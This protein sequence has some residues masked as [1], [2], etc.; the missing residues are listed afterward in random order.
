MSIQ[1]KT[2]TIS[3]TEIFELYIIFIY[4]IVHK[5][6]I[7]VH[8]LNLLISNYRKYLNIESEIFIFIQN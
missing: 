4:D 3:F 1:V 6:I 8:S 5:I 2:L 7:I